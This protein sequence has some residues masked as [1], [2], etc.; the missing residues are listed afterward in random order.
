MNPFLFVMARPVAAIVQ[1][2]GRVGPVAHGDRPVAGLVAVFGPHDRDFP[3][4]SVR[5]PVGEHGVA[6]NL[7]GKQEN[8][9]QL[10]AVALVAGFLRHGAPV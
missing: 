1:R 2:P 5:V 9:G 4:V 7:S 8:F 6:R 3:A 10:L